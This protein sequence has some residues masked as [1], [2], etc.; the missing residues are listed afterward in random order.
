MIGWKTDALSLIFIV[1][2]R[3]LNYISAYL[4]W[5]IFQVKISNF[6]FDA[7]LQNSRVE[8]LCVLKTEHFTFVQI[9]IS[10]IESKEMASL[11]DFESI[12][13]TVQRSLLSSNNW[14]FS[15]TISVDKMI[16]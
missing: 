16:K 6:L 2:L 12:C 3:R 5:V 14:N 13:I 10:I 7:N 11:D 9:T 8:T 4:F 15:A 1:L